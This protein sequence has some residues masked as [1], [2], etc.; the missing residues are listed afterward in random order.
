MPKNLSKSLI[1]LKPK[2]GPLP[3][4]LKRQQ[5]SKGP[6]R[7]PLGALSPGT[8][9]D[10]ASIP[11]GDAHGP[12]PRPAT[13]RGI[14]REDGRGQVLSWRPRRRMWISKATW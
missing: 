13:S 7:R 10:A 1:S 3:K 6:I 2:P 4:V 8:R 9:L 12:A 5:K 14:S 11:P